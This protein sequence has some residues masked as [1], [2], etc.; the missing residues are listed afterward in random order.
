M[1]DMLHIHFL[2]PKLKLDTRKAGDF[3]GSRKCQPVVALNGGFFLHDFQNCNTDSC[4]KLLSKK[5]TNEHS[6]HA[7]V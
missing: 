4:R 1:I 7:S 5:V 3:K 2:H 6:V